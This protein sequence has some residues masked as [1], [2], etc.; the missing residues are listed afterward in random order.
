MLKD[1]DSVSYNS[2]ASFIRLAVLG[3]QNC[4][5]PRNTPKIRTYSSS[6][7]SILVSIESACATSY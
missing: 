7:L 2:V 6:R 5:I 1:L 4:E 3:S